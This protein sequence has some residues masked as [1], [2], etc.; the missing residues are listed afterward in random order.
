MPNG[1]FKRGFDYPNEGFIQKAIE[2]YFES[3]G[4][5]ILNEKYTDLVCIHPETG[6][7]W[8]VEAKGETKAI[9]LDFRT[10]LG[11]LLQ[12][13]STE[14]VFYGVA[15]PDMPAYRQQTDQVQAWVRKALNLHWLLVSE[16]GSVMVVGPRN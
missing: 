10:C 7:K 12:R 8:S 6:M 15:V 2:E 9:G 4:F 5:K 3:Q 14:E 11:Q 1:Q 13:M 16:D